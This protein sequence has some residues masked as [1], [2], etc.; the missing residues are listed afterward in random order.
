MGFSNL[1]FAKNANYVRRSRLLSDTST[2]G[3]D[4]SSRRHK[5]NSEPSSAS[6]VRLPASL[7][8]GDLERG[9]LSST[10]IRVRELARDSVAN[11]IGATD[12]ARDS[13]EHSA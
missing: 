8:L 2:P 5:T 7:C 12:R 3:P 4:T 11:G 1:S 9:V 10:R 6:S 13:V